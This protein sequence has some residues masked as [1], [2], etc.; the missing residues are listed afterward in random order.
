MNTFKVLTL[1]LDIIMVKLENELSNHFFEKSLISSV[2]SK[3]VNE[4]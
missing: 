1:P 2:F 3:S 4:T